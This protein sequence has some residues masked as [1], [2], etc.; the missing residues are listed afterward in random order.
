MPALFC[1]FFYMLRFFYGKAYN[2]LTTLYALSLV[3]WAQFYLI[4]WKRKCSELMVYWDNY[5]EEYD[6]ENFR[7]QYKGIVRYSP[8]TDK[9]EVYYPNYKRI[10]KIITGIF[11]MMPVFFLAT[12]VNICFMNLDGTIAEDTILNIP[13]LN[14]LSKPGSLFDTNGMLC[15]FLPILYAQAIA[16]MNKQF[17]KVAVYTTERENHKVK[18]NY[19]N[20]IILKRYIFEFMDNYMCFFYI[21]FI[22]QN[23]ASLKSQIVSY[24]S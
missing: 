9:Q 14:D 11:F 2:Y 16:F 4:N 18:S 24:M 12:F 15:N 17:V 1:V 7:K 3:I 22:N 8:I 21:A 23:F 19:E 6:I 13:I 10:L 5:T 20:T